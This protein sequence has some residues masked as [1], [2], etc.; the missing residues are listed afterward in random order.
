MKQRYFCIT[1]LSKYYYLQNHESINTF[2]IYLN[3][4]SIKQ[5]TLKK[6]INK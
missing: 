2:C 4:Y 1:K 6:I 3:W 5:D